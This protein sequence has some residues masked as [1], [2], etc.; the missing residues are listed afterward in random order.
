M[1]DFI[2]VITEQRNAK[3]KQL[4]PEERRDVLG[5]E[6]ADKHAGIA[7]RETDTYKA[8][9]PTIKQYHK[10]FALLKQVAK[11][12]GAMLQ[13]W[14]SNKDRKLRHKRKQPLVPVEQ[15]GECAEDPDE[16]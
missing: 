5:N 10:D 1:I 11:V 3:L 12:I 16:D 6:A 9:E 7:N 13:L 8:D 15:E 4:S 2:I 14:P